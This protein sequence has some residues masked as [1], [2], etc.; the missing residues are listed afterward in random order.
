M[1]FFGGSEGIF[2]PGNS[3]CRSLCS[4]SNSEYLTAHESESARSE[5]RERYLLEIVHVLQQVCTRITNAMNV[6]LSDVVRFS[7]RSMRTSGG[8]S[9]EC[10]EQ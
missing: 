6:W 10:R 9:L 1:N 7:V 8:E 3:F 5:P 4:C 2:A